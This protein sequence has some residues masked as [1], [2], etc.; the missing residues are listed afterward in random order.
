MASLSY[1]QP[2]IDAMHAR[3]LELNIDTPVID[4]LQSLFHRTSV[5]HPVFV[6][7]TQRNPR[8]QYTRPEPVC[9]PTSRAHRGA[10]LWPIQC[11]FL[12]SRAPR[13]AGAFPASVRDHQ[14]RVH[15]GREGGAEGQRPRLARWR[16]YQ[17]RRPKRLRRSD[18]KQTQLRVLWIH[19][20]CHAFLLRQL[21]AFVWEDGRELSP[22]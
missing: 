22:R 16:S 5:L 17:V 4:A 1:L 12:V 11:P 14:D 19:R 13:R 15:R 9:H 8:H 3:A 20:G 6:R 7:L 21:A 2:Q 18:G 10:R